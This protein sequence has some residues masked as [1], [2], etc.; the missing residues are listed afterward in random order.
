MFQFILLSLYAA[1]KSV[2]FVM[3]ASLTLAGIDLHS[4][5]K[6]AEDLLRD[7]SLSLTSL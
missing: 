7:Q 1:P 3:M 2:E 4:K 6:M 5:T